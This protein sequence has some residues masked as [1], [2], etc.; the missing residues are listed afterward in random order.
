M[1]KEGTALAESFNLSEKD[2][3]K[4]QLAILFHDIGYADGGLNHEERGAQHI[5]KF[6]K[7]KPIRRRGYQYD[8]GYHSGDTNECSSQFHP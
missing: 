1:F 3:E 8:S 4:L 6:L 7:K 2:L 5:A